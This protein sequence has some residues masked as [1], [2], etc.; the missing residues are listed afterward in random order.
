MDTQRTKSTAIYDFENG[1]H[2]MATMH[3]YKRSSGENRAHHTADVEVR[4]D[5]EHRGHHGENQTYEQ[6]R[7][8]AEE[9]V[10]NELIYKVR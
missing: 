6:L 7:S 10:L 2:L 1:W 3:G 4:S 9:I 8:A 5:A